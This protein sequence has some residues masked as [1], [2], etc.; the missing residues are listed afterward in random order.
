MSV[1][2]TLTLYR[3]DDPE[4]AHSEFLS[5]Q[6]DLANGLTRW[7]DSDYFRAWEGKVWTKIFFQDQQLSAVKDDPGDLDFVLENVKALDTLE[8]KEAEEGEEQEEEATVSES[9][10]SCGLCHL[11]TSSKEELLLHVKTSHQDQEISLTHF[12]KAIAR[13]A[14]KRKANINTCDICKVSLSLV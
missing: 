9:D 5:V 8:R 4:L 13:K 11:K 14:G 10:F 7:E 6:S 3:F 12:T 2:L 1:L